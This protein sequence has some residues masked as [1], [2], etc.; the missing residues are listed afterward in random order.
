MKRIIFSVMLMLCGML[1]YA[2][3]QATSH[4]VTSGE[5]LYS[6]SR[7]YGVTV[8]DILNANPGLTENIM[9]G[10]TIKVPTVS[11]SPELQRLNPCKHTHIVQKKETIYGISH[12]Y[13]ITEEELIAANPQLQNG[14]KL[15]K[16]SELCIPYTQEEQQVHKEQQ[17][18]VM[19]QIEAKRQESIVK[20][21]DVIKI[22][23]IAPFGLEDTHRSAEAKKMTDFYK[24][25][26]MAVDTLKHRGI[27]CDVYTYEEKG[28]DGSSM[29]SILAQPMMKHVNLIVGPFRPANMAQVARFAN[30]NGIFM[31]TPM[32][33]KSYDLSNYKNLF[34]ISAPQ[35]MVYDNVARKFVNK[36]S[37]QNVIFVEIGDS[38]DNNVLMN[39]LKQKL[40]DNG[41]KFKTVSIND[42]AAI[43]DMVATDKTNVLI[44]TSSSDTA[45]RNLFKKLSESKKALEECKIR[46]FGHPEWQTYTKYKDQ[47][48]SYGAVFYS[49]FFSNP[50]NP[51]IQRF[52]R[53]FERWFRDPQIPS[54][55][56]YGE[57][58][59]DIAQYFVR[60]LHE[61]GNKLSATNPIAYEGM[62]TPFKFEYIGDSKAQFNNSV[63]L[64]QFNSDGTFKADR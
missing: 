4:V 17:V 7:Q 11:A 6:I 31:V 19:E 39:K 15:K 20:F 35:S 27:S 23:V 5:T 41:T 54:F 42:F 36:F 33:T 12:Q 57:L 55:P 18:Q 32:S 61:K 56:Q 1:I 26:L 62:Q 43:H 50:S 46:L 2:Q 34:E 9:A 21:F 3:N 25:F 49:T 38:K 53:A 40:S 45:L 48:K 44:P 22:A 63:M 30:E 64:V 51:N 29:A 37:A 24:G 16:G 60:G 10:Q 28:S 58:G 14:K 8:N 13:G 59:Y 52:N 47:L